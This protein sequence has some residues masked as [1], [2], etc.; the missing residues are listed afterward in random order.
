MGL[1]ADSSLVYVKTMDGDVLGV[2]TKADSVQVKWKGN[3]TMGYD[4]SPSVVTEHGGL[5]FALSNSGDMYAFKREDGTLA[6]VH[7][8]SNAL[9]NPLSF[10]NDHQLI[11]TTMDGVIVC[12]RY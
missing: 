2:D 12:L 5:V 3:R 10:V 4:I 9:V 11:A 1:S 8:I 6:W 7:K